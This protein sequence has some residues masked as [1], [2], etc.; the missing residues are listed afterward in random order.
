MLL[1]GRVL[2]LDD[3]V[4]D[5]LAEPRVPRIVVEDKE[6]AIPQQTALIPVLNRPHDPQAEHKPGTP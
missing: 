2:D 5:L 3:I 1:C 6:R 4:A